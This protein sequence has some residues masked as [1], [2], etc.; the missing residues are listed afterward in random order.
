MRYRLAHKQSRVYLEQ[1][2]NKHPAFCAFLSWCEE[3][4]R[5]GRMEFHDLLYQPLQRL[6][7]WEPPPS[8]S[9]ALALPI[10]SLSL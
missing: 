6:T 2:T 1:A 8:L 5:C 10:Q 7:R 3:D 9:L 4:D